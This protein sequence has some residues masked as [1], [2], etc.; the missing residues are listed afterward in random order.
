MMR[1]ILNK[2]VKEIGNRVIT[3]RPELQGQLDYAIAS[4]KKV[5]DIKDQGADVEDLEV[6]TWCAFRA[7]KTIQPLLE[8]AKQGSNSK[9]LDKTWTTINSLEN[10]TQIR[11]LLRWRG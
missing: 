5:P 3:T 11:L 7:A 4:K 9:G 1:R 2:A 6:S 8:I 10:G